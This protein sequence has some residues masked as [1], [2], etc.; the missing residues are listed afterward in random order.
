MAVLAALAGC[1]GKS[2]PNPKPTPQKTEQKAEAPV[3][4]TN[5]V[6]KPMNPLVLIT[7]SE[8]PIKVELWP[9]KAPATVANFLAY[10]KEGFFDGTIFHRV[11]PT[12]MIQ[13]GGF[14][15]DMQQKPTHAPVKNEARSDVPNKRGT[16]AMARTNVV[17]SATGQFFINVVDNA[18]LDHRDDTPRGF[19]YCVFGQVVEGMDVVDRIRQTPTKEVGPFS[20][21]PVK[22][23]VI[24]SVKVVEQK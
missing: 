14:T 21:V 15:P 1:Q 2:A 4:K 3:A 6:A 9:D 17:D 7:T 13:G 10:T 11:I 23:M 16:L 8:G 24:Q 18:F 20:D 12:F 5:E 19:G 22:P